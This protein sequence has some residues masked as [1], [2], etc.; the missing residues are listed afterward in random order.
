LRYGAIIKY[1]KTE[2]KMASCEMKLKLAGMDNVYHFGD[3]IDG[4]VEVNVANPCP[5]PRLV[6]ELGWDTHGLGN[7]DVQQEE[8]VEPYTAVWFP[9]ETYRYRFKFVAPDGPP[10]YHGHLLNVNW[11]VRARADLPRA[12]CDTNEH[13]ILLIAGEGHKDKRSESDKGMRGAAEASSLLPWKRAHSTS[14]VDQQF[15]P[16]ASAL[17]FAGLLLL[18]GIGLVAHE[19]LDGIT[20]ARYSGIEMTPGILGALYIAGFAL[21]SMQKLAPLPRPYLHWR[22]AL[23][24][25]VVAATL[26]AI[27]Y[28]VPNDLVPGWIRQATPA[29]GALLIIVALPLFY[30]ARRES[31]I[32]RM[33]IRIQPT[34]LK[35]GARI[36]CVLEAELKREGSP[37]T[38][39]AT[40]TA[41]EIVR[42]GSGTRTKRY[43]HI[44]YEDSIPLAP[45]ELAGSGREATLGASLVVPSSGPVNFASA[46]NEVA[47]KVTLRVMGEGSAAWERSYPIRVI[48]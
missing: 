43:S 46:H 14:Q 20:W 36:D 17:A 9:G 48:I 15:V 13:E 22:S 39:V 40:L 42:I 16:G 26:I 2:V 10:T 32:G 31:R 38:A 28:T 45:T 29:I 47:W 21:A 12:G 11:F 41:R 34:A 4:V 5:W 1:L 44:A 19:H 7:H 35:R 23:G 30:N 33:E 37:P 8:I 27:L 24:S 6:I 18:L 3:E 25:T